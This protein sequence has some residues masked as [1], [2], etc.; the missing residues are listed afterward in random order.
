MIYVVGKALITN[1]KNITTNINL[2][3][4]L[5]KKTLIVN[6]SPTKGAQKQPNTVAPVADESSLAQPQVFC[7]IDVVRR[8]FA[9]WV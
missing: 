1:H 3:K 5:D 6:T 2:W 4:T 7:E 8:S 9:V